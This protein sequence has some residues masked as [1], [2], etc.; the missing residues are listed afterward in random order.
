M[1][2]C[3]V[4]VEYFGV[5]FAAAIF[6]LLA[7]VVPECLSRVPALAGPFR[8]NRY[9]AA[10]EPSSFFS[11]TPRAFRSVFDSSSLSVVVT[12]VMFIP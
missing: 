3:T 1:Q 4:R 7:M 6:D 10:S 8:R 9:A 2:R 5:R 12:I 11:G